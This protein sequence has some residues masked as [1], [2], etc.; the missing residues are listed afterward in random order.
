MFDARGRAFG[1]NCTGYEG[2]AVSYLARVEQVLSLVAHG[3]MLG[4]DQPPID[5]TLLQL[6]QTGHVLFDPKIS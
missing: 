5:R 6:A 2:I 4:P 1:I 3:M